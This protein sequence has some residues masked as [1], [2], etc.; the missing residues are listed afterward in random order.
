LYNI[1]YI[2]DKELPMTDPNLG[3][4]GYKGRCRRVLER[5]EKDTVAVVAGAP[6]EN[7]LKLFRQA[8]D[9]Y[10]LTGVESPQ[11]YLL[12]D[13]RSDTTTL[14]LPHQTERERDSIGPI[15]SV[16]SADAVIAACGVDDVL[17][18]EK[19]ASKLE[20]VTKIYTPFREGAG[21]MTSWDTQIAGR[22]GRFSDPWD[23]SLDRFAHFIE[24][25]RRRYPVAEVV[26][27]VPVLNE[28]RGVKDD[29]EIGLLRRSGKLSALGIV[30]AMKSTRPGLYE[31]QLAA[32]LDYVYMNHGAR[33]RSYNVIMASG[34]N[35]W[36]GHYGA[37]SS[38]L[39]DGD[40]ILGDCAPDY[41][42][43]A[44]DIGRMWPVNGTYTDEQRQLYGFM[45]EFHKA[46]LEE[47]KPGL[48][49]E[50]IRITVA[51]R[52]KKVAAATKWIR[53]SF[54]KAA[55]WSL[56]F[57]YHMSHP[58]G[59]ACH[60]DGHYRG[61]P[62]VPGVVIA[63]D[64]QIRVDEERKYVR[65]EDTIVVTEDGV[66]NFTADAPL[67]LDEV[68]ALMRE[69]GMVQRYPADAFPLFPLC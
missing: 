8:N 35:A 66:E 12:L 7:G 46:Y 21:S 34:A 47:I 55:E 50:Q 40:L 28:L 53:P 54:E 22:N 2:V 38:I 3:P 15:P 27:L 11:S 16:E 36:H 60:D 29:H 43:Y 62:L 52:M 48:T 5:M 14:F 18:L 67:E 25:L 37:N 58:V 10:Y 17:G 68:E 23:G 41:R 42:Y 69:E 30:E 56:N 9:F 19:L 39:Q 59:L 32:V 24:L 63:L 13:R 61:K 4:D 20:R 64:P 45:V 57:P 65:V 51:G 1:K 31:Y 26:D 44:S 33:G 6:E 49:D